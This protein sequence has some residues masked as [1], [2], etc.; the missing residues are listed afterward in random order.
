MASCLLSKAPPMRNHLALSAAFIVLA[1]TA[2]CETGPGAAKEPPLL[3][4]TSPT[5][6]LVQG[7]AGQLTVTGT[8]MPN[9]QGDAVEK[10][11]VNNVQAQLSADGSFTATIDVVEGATLIQTVA[12]DANGTTVTDT[13]AVQAGQ[14]RAVGANIDRA[15]AVSMSADAFAKLSAAAGPI[16]KGLNMPAM[17]APLQPML[18]AGSG[19]TYARLFVD[20]LK[21]SDVQISLSPAQGAL[22]FRAELDQLD[23]PAHAQFAVLGVGGTESLRVTASRVV[24]AG[25]LNITPAGLSGLKTKIVHPDLQ[26]TGFHV[27]AGGIP[28]TI[29]NLLHIDSVL[30]TVIPVG[31][32]LAMGPLVNLALGALG[33]PQQLDVMG[34]KLDMQVAPSTIAF[35]P[36][37]AV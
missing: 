23:M 22:M 36:T 1:A 7:H 32:E 5:R 20:D 30:Q 33:G 27:E 25:T 10:V 6:G 2:G 18:N 15:I 31:A 19:S 17:L 37:G 21:F 4:V 3:T 13:R 34:K 12:R 26:V 9:T 35:D 16:I 28:T 24:V 11:L 8:A 14:L 29:L